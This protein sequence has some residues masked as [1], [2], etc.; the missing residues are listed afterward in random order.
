[1]TPLLEI[2]DL[3]IHFRRGDGGYAAAVRGVDLAV[4]EGQ[5]V[6]LVGES[7][8]GKSQTAAAVLGLTPPHGRVV[9]GRI[10]FRGRN[11]LGLGPGEWRGLRGRQIALIPQEAFGALNPCLRV[12]S[13][14]AESLEAHL[15]MKGSPAR[16]RVVELLEVV[17]MNEPERVAKLY[18]HQLSGGMRQ[19]VTIA[20]AL[21]CEPDLLLADEP[22]TALDAV[23]HRQ[24]LELLAAA[25]RSRGG[26]LLLITHD[27]VQARWI[28]DRIAVMYAG[29]VVEE[30]PADRVFA[31]PRHPYTRG[32]LRSS[33]PIEA[34]R[35]A[36]PEIPG[37][38]P[39]LW[40]LPAG[41]AFHPRCDRATAECRSED[42]GPSREAS[43]R[44]FQ[45]HHPCP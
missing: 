20:I 10:G 9:R 14:V 12:G 5:I 26:G 25:A 15:A 43:E 19:R 7:G 27:L 40:D 36:V 34:Q 38:P 32:L 4:Q 29:R 3:E 42:P 44:S 24:I 41:C 35:E 45:C 17:G 2:S 30:G 22:T 39:N 31:E 33:L 11:L 1:M 13:Q 18:P 28:G 21:A 23:T 16:R 8:S 37:R 6:G